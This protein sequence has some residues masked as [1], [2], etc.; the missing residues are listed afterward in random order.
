VCGQVPKAL[1]A[2]TS[3][4]RTSDG[5][6][7]YSATA[8]SGSTAIVLAHESPGGMCG[9]LP[10][11]R[12]IQ[13]HGLQALAFDFRGFQ[14][15]DSPRM[16]IYDDLGPDLQAAVDAAHADG[17]K[18]VFVMGASFGGAAALTF[19][20]QLHGVDGIVNLSGELNLVGRDLDAIDAVPKLHVPLLFI[21]S[22]DD[23][24]LDAGDA[25]KLEH[26]AGS[27]D[28]Q[29]SLYPGTYHGWDLLYLAP[30]R[31]RVWSRILGWVEGYQS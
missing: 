10:A 28:K 5:V 31:G 29:L 16:A 18:K 17:A 24:Y 1:H 13:A 21:A 4:L 14:P 20:S 23:P 26:A 30:F 2:Q 7:L 22:R 12:F 27:T 15:S 9:W 6:R 19:G 8:G 3:W 25:Q 11:M